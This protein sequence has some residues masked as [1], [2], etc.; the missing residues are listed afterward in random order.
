MGPHC[1]MAHSR[2]R[3]KYDPCPRDL[4]SRMDRIIAG[5][6]KMQENISSQLLVASQGN[7]NQCDVVV[8]VL[9]AYSQGC[10][11]EVTSGCP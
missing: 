2:T 6:G 3:P 10:W 4:L 5:Q 1:A 9:C 8:V 7:N 11:L